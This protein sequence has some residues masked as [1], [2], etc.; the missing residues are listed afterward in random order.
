M[1]KLLVGNKADLEEDRKV[2]KSEGEE[3]AN[4]FKMPF[5]EVSA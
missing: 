1:N 2:K 3:L 4:E 5:I